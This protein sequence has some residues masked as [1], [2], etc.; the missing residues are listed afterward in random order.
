MESIDSYP[1]G[2]SGLMRKSGSWFHP[3]L[4]HCRC[5]PRDDDGQGKD[6]AFWFS[7]FK[8]LTLLWKA[9]KSIWDWELIQCGRGWFGLHMTGCFKQD[10][11]MN[12]R[13]TAKQKA[14]HAT[15]HGPSGVYQ[16]SQIITRFCWIKLASAVRYRASLVSCWTYS[17]QLRDLI[18]NHNLTPPFIDIQTRLDQY[19][20][21]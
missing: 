7:S 1:S 15:Q 5:C 14:S 11:G 19:T 18:T 16:E 12:Y 13:N 20:L 21:R 6:N 17:V 2:S 10:P 9:D 4:I 3:T 8:P